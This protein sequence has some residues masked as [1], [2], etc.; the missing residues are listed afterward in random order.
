VRLLNHQLECVS[1]CTRPSAFI[2]CDLLI[3]Q[4]EEVELKEQALTFWLSVQMRR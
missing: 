3:A 4:D 2:A 1:I